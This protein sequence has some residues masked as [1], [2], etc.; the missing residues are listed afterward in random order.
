MPSAVAFSVGNPNATSPAG[1]L[2]SSKTDWRS[3]EMRTSYP[4]TGTG[5]SRGDEPGGD[6]GGREAMD[7]G[8]R[9]LSGVVGR[10]PAGAH[11]QL[12]VTL[13]RVV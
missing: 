3:G 5:W 4:K 6:L 8:R 2:K 7:P 11:L 12:R 1:V 10:V 13:R 9:R